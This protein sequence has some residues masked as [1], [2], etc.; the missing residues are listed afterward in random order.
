MR[1]L[2]AGENALS[3]AA[4]VVEVAAVGTAEVELL[5]PQPV[6]VMSSPADIR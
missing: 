1:L 5:A 2:G 4:I 6:G 3:Q